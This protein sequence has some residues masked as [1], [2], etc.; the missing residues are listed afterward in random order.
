MDNAKNGRWVIP[1]KKFCTVRVKSVILFHTMFTLIYYYDKVFF[2]KIHNK[3]IAK[4]NQGLS[5]RLF[6]RP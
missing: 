4:L 1:F 6:E 3:N 5:N 2:N